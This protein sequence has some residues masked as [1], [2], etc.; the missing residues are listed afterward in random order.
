MSGVVRG[1]DSI[2][3]L[4]LVPVAEG[5]DRAFL[6]EEFNRIFV[7]RPTRTQKAITVFQ[8]KDDLLPFEEAKLYGHNAAH[9]LLAFLARELGCVRIAEA[10]EKPDLIPFVRDAFVNESGAAL[11]AKWSGKDELFTPS[12]FAAY[13]DDLLERMTRRS[14]NDTVERVARDPR[15]KLGYEDRFFGTIRLCLEFGTGGSRFAFGAACALSELLGGARA[16]SDPAPFLRELWGREDRE[17]EETAR[18]AWRLL[19]AWREAGR[20]KLREF[21]SGN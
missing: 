3:E 20:P 16:E 5:S 6:V 8:E 9:A 15:R 2:E 4:G 12:G 17:L 18:R 14:L 13:A 21:W 19:C 10:T 1:R 7:S 11:I